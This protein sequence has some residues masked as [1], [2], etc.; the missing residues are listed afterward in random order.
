MKLKREKIA[1][2]NDQAE[3]SQTYFE[4]LNKLKEKIRSTQ[5]KAMIKVNQELIQLY[6]EIG[7]AISE[8]QE[9]EA[10][11]EKPKSEPE[12]REEKNTRTSA[13][14]K[15]KPDLFGHNI[16]VSE[17]KE[18]AEATTTLPCCSRAK[19][20]TEEGARSRKELEALPIFEEMTPS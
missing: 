8:K 10:A 4:T 17:I 3:L 15:K 14:N 9:K 13:R 11:E 16:M 5:I 7:V 20:R 1:N 19:T 6:W 12:Q 18:T 2:S